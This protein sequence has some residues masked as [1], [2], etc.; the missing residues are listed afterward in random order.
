LP[1]LSAPSISPNGGTFTSATSVTLADTDGTA[2]MYYTT[3]GNTPTSG[4]TKYIGSFSLSSSATVKAIAVAASGLTSPIT[5]ATFTVNIPVLTAPTVSLTPAVTTAGSPG[6]LTLLATSN[7]NGS[8]VTFGTAGSIGGTFNPATCVIATGSCATRYLPTGSLSAATYSND[9][10]AAFTATGSYNTGSASSTL[11]VNAGSATPTA[12]NLFNFTNTAGSGSYTGRALY[13]GSLIQAKDGLL[14]G[15]T[16]RGGNT[17]ASSFGGGLVFSFSP[18]TSA[19]NVVFSFLGGSGD[20]LNPYDGVIQ[21][22]LDGML[23]GTTFEGNSANLGVIFKVGTATGT[24]SDTILHNFTG[25]TTDGSEPYSGLIPVVIS[26]TNVAFYGN[27]YSGGTNGNGAIYSLTSSGTYNQLYSL[28][29]TATPSTGGYPRGSLVQHPTD[30]F[31]YGA[32]YNGGSGSGGTIFKIDVNGNNYQVL[33]NFYTV[34]TDGKSP[35]AGLI[36]G[37]DGYLYGTT[38]LGG[39]NSNGTVFKI[40]YQGNNYSVIYSFAAS[41]TDGSKPEDALYLASDGLLYGTTSIGGTNN[42]GT[43]FRMNTSGGAY[44]VLYSFGPLPNGTTPYSGLMQASDG[45]FYGGTSAGGGATTTVSYGTLFKVPYGP[46]PIQLAAPA[47]VTHGSSFSLAYSVA[48][49]YSTTLQNCFATNNA[50]DTTG[51]AGLKTGLPSPQTVTLTA[52]SSGTYTYT[53]T[54]GG[55][56]SGFTTLVVQ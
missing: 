5:S 51:W 8:T 15:T 44:T 13:Y 22:P 3:N 47:T 7:A 42:L 4:S 1:I 38:A 25:T 10:T 56:E 18:A 53:L 34:T 33:H 46:A 14:Y 28:N 50:G 31:L 2:V 41:S 19:Y 55:A 45:N 6:G 12:V 49:A 40:D 21:G 23:Y 20:G 29:S 32:A 54:C 30:G 11:T 36:V 24:S 39:T 35:V 16:E 9:L 43:I 27:V 48:N 26:P 37:P 52:P 17:T